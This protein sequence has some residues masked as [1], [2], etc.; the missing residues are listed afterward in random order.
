M[1][2]GP[3]ISSAHDERL[4]HRFWRV[5]KPLSL[6]HGRDGWWP[7]GRAWHHL[8]PSPPILRVGA[9]TRYVFGLGMQAHLAAGWSRVRV[10]FELVHGGRT[11]DS[12]DVH[13]FRPSER[14]S[15]RLAHQERTSEDV[16]RAVDFRR[17]T[18]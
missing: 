8:P 1:L 18:V 7:G 2:Y 13:G 15:A 10:Q 11:G 6:D 5:L 16:P 4:R 3:R 12:G 9:A 14:E 17:R